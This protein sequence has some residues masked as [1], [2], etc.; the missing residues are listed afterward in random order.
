MI[1]LDNSDMMYVAKLLE[2]SQRHFKL[3]EHSSREL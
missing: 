3:R 2:Y 1:R